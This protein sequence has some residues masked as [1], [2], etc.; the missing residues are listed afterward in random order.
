MVTRM[1][2]I[3]VC[4]VLAFASCLAARQCAQRLGIREIAKSEACV[5]SPRLR[6]MVDAEV[7]D[8]KLTLTPFRRIRLLLTPHFAAATK[9]FT[10]TQSS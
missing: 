5:Q 9:S 6:Q 10:V 7:D 1:Q 8:I 2:Q 4:L 3:A